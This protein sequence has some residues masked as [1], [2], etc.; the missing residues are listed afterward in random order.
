MLVLDDIVSTIDS[1]HRNR[2]CELLFENF[3]EKQILITTHDQ[4]WY[5]QIIATQKM[6]NI[7]NKFKN[8]MI[9]RWD[10]NTGL[11]LVPYRIRAETIQTKLDDLDKQGAGN[12]IRQYLEF[13]LSEAC[14]NFV[15]KIPFRKTG[16]YTL[17]D[18]FENFAGRISQIKLYS[19]N[20]WRDQILRIYTE[21]DAYRSMI[22]SLSHFNDISN[23]YSIEEIKDVFMITK[24]LEKSMSCAGCNSMIEYDQS[25]KLIRCVNHK[26]KVKTIYQ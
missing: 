24:E 22:N 2:I 11:D 19:N 23:S 21:L 12:E 3:P 6:F 26:C 18:Y 5:E 17:N 15:V 13:I 1:N 9:K 10:V 4:I 20:S 25:S 7:R 16:K 8:Y 14:Q